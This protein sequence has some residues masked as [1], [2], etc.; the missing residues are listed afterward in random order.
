MSSRPVG[1]TSFTLI[2]RVQKFP[3]DVEAWDEFVLRYHPMI[4]AW[5]VKWGLQVADA[6]DVSQIVLVKLMGAMRR[7][8]Y[9]PSRSFS[10]WLKTVTHN[11]W[12]DFCNDRRKEPGQVTTGISIAEVSAAR[13]EFARQ[14]ENLF[15][16][17]L[18]ETA[19]HRVIN[20]VKPVT[21]ECFRLM[22]ARRSLGAGRRRAPEDSRGARV[23]GQEPRSE[24]SSGRDPNYER[25]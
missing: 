23:R 6:D 10:G 18:F 2:E 7:F 14:I 15:D 4:H 22:R 19:M 3:A 20:R 16:R 12:T 21:W 1:N 8:H 25:R 9:D 5:C 17:D 11:T 24:A 13:V